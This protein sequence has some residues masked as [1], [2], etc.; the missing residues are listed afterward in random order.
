MINSALFYEER[1]RGVV[2]RFLKGVEATEAALAK[3]P[4]WGQPCEAG[5][6]KWRVKKSPYAVINKG[7]SDHIIVFAVVHFSHRP[8]Y[9]LERL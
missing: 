3:Q 1:N 9:W 2:G 5:T 6:R 7:Y 4:L 8:G